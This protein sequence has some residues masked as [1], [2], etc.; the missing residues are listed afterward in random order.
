M[1]PIPP[2]IADLALRSE[3]LDAM[4]DGAW[5]N[6]SSLATKMEYATSSRELSRILIKLVRLEV[7]HRRIPTDGPTEY[8]RKHLEQ[9]RRAKVALKMLVGFVA[10]SDEI[11]RHECRLE[12]QC[13]CEVVAA[14]P[15]AEWCECPEACEYFEA[16]PDHARILHALPPLTSVAHLQGEAE[17]DIVVRN[18]ARE[19]ARA[20]WA[21]RTEEQKEK[22]RKKDAARRARYDAAIAAKKASRS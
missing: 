18:H 7:L 1:K 6:A 15:D 19:Q 14:M 8:R 11:R 16:I 10:R 13:V 2:S 21:K 12:T 9:Q 5:Y 20:A 3:V 17:D 22:Q 4:A